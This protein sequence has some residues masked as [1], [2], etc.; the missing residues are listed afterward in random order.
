MRTLGIFLIVIGLVLALV[1][2]FKFF[3]KEK[4]VD[5][6]NIEVTADKPH[7]VNWSPYLGIGIMVVGG[8]IFIASRRQRL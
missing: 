2:G 6:G 8:I 5:I 4:V 7:A 3:T 1:T